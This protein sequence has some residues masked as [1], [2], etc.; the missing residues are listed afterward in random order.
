M[1][2]LWGWPVSQGLFVQ[3]QLSLTSWA[4]LCEYKG[5]KTK[6]FNNLIECS[7]LLS[8]APNEPMKKADGLSSPVLNAPLNLKRIIHSF[9]WTWVLGNHEQWWWQ[10]LENYVYNLG[11]ATLKVGYSQEWAENTQKEPCEGPT[12]RSTDPWT[13]MRPHGI[14]CPPLKMFYLSSTSSSGTIFASNDEGIDLEAAKSKITPTRN[15]KMRPFPI[16]F[17]SKKLSYK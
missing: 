3:I 1:W 14:V 10:C 16:I 12:N 2:F 8:M 17:L 15:R 11:R 7:H 13:K 6:V 9:T 5:C 4:D